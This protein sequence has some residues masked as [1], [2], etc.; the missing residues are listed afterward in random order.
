MHLA[1]VLDRVEEALPLEAEGVEVV[2]TA[3]A[4]PQRGRELEQGGAGTP[5]ARPA[6]EGVLTT[7]DDGEAVEA[8]AGARERAFA[9]ED[10][11]TMLD[12]RLL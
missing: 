2:A 1:A 5:Q 10:L 12:G 3:Q 9:A 8:L 11:A 4:D 7:P 6:T